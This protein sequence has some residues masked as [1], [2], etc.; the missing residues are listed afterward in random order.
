[1]FFHGVTY[2]FPEQRRLV[3]ALRLAD[4]ALNPVLELHKLVGRV[5]L[6]DHK[7]CIFRPVRLVCKKIARLEEKRLLLYR[8][9]RHALVQRDLALHRFGRGPDL[10]NT[11]EHLVKVVF[12]DDGCHLNFLHQR[13]TV[14]LER[15]QTVHQIVGIA[16]RSGIA[17]REERI[18]RS[19]GM[20]A[21]FAFHVLRLVQD[22]HRS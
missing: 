20:D 10:L 4:S 18:E 19:Q 11:N 7:A 22:Q 21:P 17:Q 9:P 3:P 15:R 1:M 5:D 6:I 2:L 12:L 8:L 16:M 14:S 13:L